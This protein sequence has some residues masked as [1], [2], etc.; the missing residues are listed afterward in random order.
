VVDWHGVH[1]LPQQPGKAELTAVIP[2]RAEGLRVKNFAV[3]LNQNWKPTQ[4]HP[5]V[6]LGEERA[7]LEHFGFTSRTVDVA[8]AHGTPKGYELA[9]RVLKTTAGPAFTS[10]WVVS[11]RGTRGGRT[12]A[13]PFG[14]LLCPAQSTDAREC[15]VQGS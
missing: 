8:C 3:R 2:E 10:G 9:V 6:F 15:Q 4:G 5:G 1:D 12:L 7:P 11:Y 13:I 14:L